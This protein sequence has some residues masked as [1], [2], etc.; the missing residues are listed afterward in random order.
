MM[1]GRNCD[2]WCR[3]NRLQ[4]IVP[5]EVSAE[6]CSLL[7]GY[8]YTHGYTHCSMSNYHLSRCARSVSTG[9]MHGP[10]RSSGIYD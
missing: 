3:V 2:G 1:R 4:S 5:V 10:R 7:N 9:I 6:I 8:P